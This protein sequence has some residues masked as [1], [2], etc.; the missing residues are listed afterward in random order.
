MEW[1]GCKHE[2]LPGYRDPINLKTNSIEKAVKLTAFLFDRF[3]SDWGGV[4]TEARRHGGTEGVK[5]N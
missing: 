2:V 4:Y 5:V 1:R 3:F